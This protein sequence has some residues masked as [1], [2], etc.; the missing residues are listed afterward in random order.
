MYVCIYHNGYISFCP[1]TLIILGSQKVHLIVKLWRT[2]LGSY[3]WADGRT[4]TGEQDSQMLN[5]LDF[6]SWILVAENLPPLEVG[7]EY[8]A[9]SWAQIDEQLQ[10]EN[11]DF[12]D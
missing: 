10:V 5:M 6:C 4:Y 8:D 12:G 11:D 3:A 9:W 7:E 2:G 1:T